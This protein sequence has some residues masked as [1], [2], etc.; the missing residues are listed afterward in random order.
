MLLSIAI[1]SLMVST[2]CGYGLAV[3]IVEDITK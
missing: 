1:V 3:I 2:V